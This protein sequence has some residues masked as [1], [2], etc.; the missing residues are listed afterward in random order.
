M[1]EK[2]VEK[3]TDEKLQLEKRIEI[4]EET[5]SDHEALRGMAEEQEEVIVELEHEMREELDMQLREVSV[6]IR[7][8]IESTVIIILPSMSSV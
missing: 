6:L 5:V 2:M 7:S 8:Y 4:L 3:M 1:V